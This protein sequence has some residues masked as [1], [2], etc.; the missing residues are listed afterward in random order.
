MR[1]NAWVFWGLTAFFFIVGNVYA[2]WG[3]I[4]KG[5]IDWSGGTPLGLC[6]L[7]CGMIAFF[8]NRT[9]RTQGGELPQDRDNAKIDEDDPEMGTFS[10]WSWWPFALAGSCFL[11]FLG[12][13]VGGWL[14]IIGAAFAVVCL[15]GWVFEYYRGYFSR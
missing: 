7:L 6:A 14:A 8:L 5:Y 2:G 13:A 1:I 15:V 9:H 4:S 11:T 12:L 10:P 3:L